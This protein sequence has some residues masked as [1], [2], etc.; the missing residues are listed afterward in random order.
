MW[1]ESELKQRIFRADAYRLMLKSALEQTER[2]HHNQVLRGKLWIDACESNHPT[3]LAERGITAVVSM[4][5][6][7]VREAYTLK[8]ATRCWCTVKRAFRAAPRCA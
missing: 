2:D 6:V 7:S 1:D 3:I 4:G 5:T 8:K